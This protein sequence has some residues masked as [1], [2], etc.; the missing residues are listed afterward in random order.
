MRDYLAIYN[1]WGREVCRRPGYANEWDASGQSPGTYYYL[2]H[3]LAN[4][5]RYTGCVEVV[6]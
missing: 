5:Q 4:G 6:R 1:R 3:N 2:L